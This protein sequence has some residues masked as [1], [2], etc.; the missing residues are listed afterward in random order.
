MSGQNVFFLAFN[1][2]AVVEN[3]LLNFNLGKSKE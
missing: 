1:V 2:A 3:G